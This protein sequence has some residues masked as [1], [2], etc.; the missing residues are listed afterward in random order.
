MAKLYRKNGSEISPCILSQV[1]YELGLKTKKAENSK[2]CSDNYW[3]ETVTIVAIKNV[4][5]LTQYK[6]ILR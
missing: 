6:L 2:Q 5:P 3:N 4:I 1:R